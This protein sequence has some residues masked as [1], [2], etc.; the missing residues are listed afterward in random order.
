VG[1][2]CYTSGRAGGGSRVPLGGATIADVLRQ[3]WG[4]LI[5]KQW[6]ILYPL[7]LSV[8]GT[9]AFLAVYA[10]D[11][12]SLGWSAFFNTDFNRWEYIREHFLTDFSLTPEFA[13]AVFAG[14]VFCAIAAM[15]RAPFFRAIA[16]YRYPL[17]PRG[18]AEAARLFVFY[19][20]L[21]LVTL[22]LPLAAPIKGNWATLVFTLVQIIALLVVFSDY[23]IVFEDVG[24]IRGLRRS[25]RLVGL[26]F[27]AV[28]LIFIVLSLLWIGVE[29]LYGLYYHDGARVFPLLPISRMLVE[30]LLLL[31]GD[32]VFI[33][34]YE[35][36]RRLS[37]S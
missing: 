27:L 4:R 36:V 32:L 35:D 37:P 13:V 21:Y 8:V 10:A 3:A 9:L 25:F 23:V 22:I 1:G 12:K 6:L 2:R 33:F 18:W 17:A 11:G 16:G 29:S 24:P 28:L 15:I 19:L 14:I 34:L 31:I 26:R 20:L 7:A 5:R 30:S